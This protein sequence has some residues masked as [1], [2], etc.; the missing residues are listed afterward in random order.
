MNTKKKKKSSFKSTIGGG[1]SH[2][3]NNTE[4]KSVV[5]KCHESTLLGWGFKIFRIN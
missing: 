2:P 3:A 4:F 1:T 5:T